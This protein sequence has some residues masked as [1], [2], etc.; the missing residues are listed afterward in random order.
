MTGGDW[1]AVAA[2]ALLIALAGVMA[3]SEV[4]IT[5]ISR[6]RAYR[7]QEEGRRGAGSLVRISEDP[8]RYLNVILLLTLLMH[9][10][11]TTIAT[12]VAV[13]VVGGL[14]E[15]VATVSMTVLLFVLAEV[16]PKTF[17][18]Q[19]TDRVGL[20]LA[21]VIVALGRMLG[22]V[23]QAL[24]T[25]ANVLAPGKGLPEGPF[26]TEQEIKQMAETAAEEEEIEEEEKELI[27]S[28]FEFGDTVVREVMVPRPD[29]AAVDVL[30]PL[31][32]VAAM[33]IE[34]GYSRIPVFKDSLD[35]IVG[36]VY[37]K[38]VLRS[39][40]TSKN[41]RDRKTKDIARKPYFVPESKKVADLLRD[42]QR[43]RLHLA[44]VV[45]EYGSVAGL[46]TLED[47]IEEI[48]GEIE[49]EFDRAEPNVKPVGDDRYRLNAKVSVDDVNDLL[50]V[51]LPDTEWDTVGGLMLGILGRVPRQGEAVEFGDLRFTAERVQGRRISQ[52]LVERVDSG[53]RVEASPE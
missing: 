8:A 52:V 50:E 42:M 2:V 51:K 20:R 12:V 37:A 21:P 40:R 31:D 53:S 11:G 27:H 30:E 41:G 14:G 48:V 16:T 43:E 28:I 46:V 6:I 47:L 45:D 33:V 24:I 25:V 26:V 3:A 10:G 22:P 5:R 23:A 19:H 44:I 7:L 36:V 1:A 38:D 15:L 4:A 17:S 13:R 29:I 39:L 35:E 49:D 34:H 9:L 18:V 32:R